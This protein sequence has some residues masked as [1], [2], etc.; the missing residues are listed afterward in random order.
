MTDGLVSG[1]VEM[2]EEL[3][4]G[5]VEMT[6]ELVSGAVEMAGELVSGSV[7]TTEGDAPN[8]S[9]R[10]VGAATEWRDLGSREQGISPF[11]SLRN[12]QSK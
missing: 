9:S 1:S 2:T 10:P 6:E 7:E 8:P 3:V 11:R 12:L 4:S 5:A